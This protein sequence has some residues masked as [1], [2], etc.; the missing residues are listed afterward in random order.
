MEQLR[1]LASEEALDTILGPSSPAYEPPTSKKPRQYRRKPRVS[2]QAKG[3]KEAQERARDDALIASLD[4]MLRSRSNSSTPVQDEINQPASKWPNTARD[5]PI[6]REPFTPVNA[7]VPIQARRD[8][9]ARPV[10]ISEPPNRL[11]TTLLAHLN[12]PPMVNNSNNGNNGNNGN[13]SAFQ[14]LV[15]QNRLQLNPD[16]RQFQ[17]TPA[18]VGYQPTQPVTVAIGG[19]PSTNSTVQQPNFGPP[20]QQSTPVLP[21]IPERQQERILLKRR[22]AYHRLM[23]DAVMVSLDTTP[24][25]LLDRYATCIQ[26]MAATIQLALQ[27]NNRTVYHV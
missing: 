21:S 18:V 10:V 19:F 9:V 15:P 1:Y 20:L 13:N 22:W 23:V 24:S 8:D 17:A 5:A 25:C 16:A 7:F 26:A 3:S 4:F 6:R 27:D 12:A 14:P 11:P 2:P